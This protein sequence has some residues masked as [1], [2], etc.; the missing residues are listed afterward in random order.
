MSPELFERLKKLDEK[1][2]YEICFGSNGFVGKLVNKDSKESKMSTG[3]SADDL[4]LWILEES[5]D[6][7]KTKEI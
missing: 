2:K 4:A 3:K 1:W 6:T 5:S 7:R